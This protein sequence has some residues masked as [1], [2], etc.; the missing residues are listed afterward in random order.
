MARPGPPPFSCTTA[1]QRPPAALTSCCWL[2]PPPVVP[3]AAP[4][5]AALGTEAPPSR[6][7]CRFGGAPPQPPAFAPHPPRCHARQAAKHLVQEDDFYR[8]RVPA[9]AVSPGDE[10][11]L[12]SVSALLAAHSAAQ[13]YQLVL[14]SLQRCLAAAGL[15]EHFDVHVDEYGHILSVAFRVDADCT[16][17][18]VPVAVV[19]LDTQSALAWLNPKD[20]AFN[21]T[22]T[23]HAGLLAPRG[24]T[25]YLG[26]SSSS[27]PCRKLRPGSLGEEHLEQ[28][29]QPLLAVPLAARHAA[30][31]HSTQV[32][33]KFR[34]RL[35]H[36]KQVLSQSIW[37]VIASLLLGAT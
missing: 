31:S 28:A 13:A 21:S 3:C 6:P 19:E 27:T 12:F 1:S 26:F 35:C 36:S 2:Y 30:D 22:V 32:V 8:L 7:A 9:D 33:L 5:T 34:Y 18:Q 10:F 23:V 14:C 37:D 29:Q 4:E 24:C 20:A 15:R 16:A 17:A 25:S 11:V